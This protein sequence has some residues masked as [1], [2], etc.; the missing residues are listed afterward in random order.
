MNFAHY[1]YEDKKSHNLRCSISHRE[2]YLIGLLWIR[3]HWN[4][5]REQPEASGI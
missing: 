4:T 1:S 3:S 5:H 2:G